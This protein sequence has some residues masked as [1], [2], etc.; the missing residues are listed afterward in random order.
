MGGMILL[1]LASAV[2]A[3]PPPK[4][5]VV[6]A[7][8][9]YRHESI[10]TAEDV[11]ASMAAT[12][13]A[14]VPQFIR[15]EKELPAA[16][17]PEAL[18]EARVVMF[19]NTTGDLKW[20]ER[21]RLLDWIAAGGSFVGVHSAS[22]TW[23][24]WPEYLEMLGGEFE[25]HPP[26]SQV[27]VHVD[28]AFHPATRHMTTP[29]TIFEEIYLFKRFSRERVHML[30]SLRASPEDGSPG[31]FPL[32]WRRH[33]GR[34]LVLYTALGHRIDVWESQWFQ[35]HLEGLIESALAHPANRR[36]AVGR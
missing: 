32:A 26:E 4:I 33:H 8:S 16:L 12:G 9:G 21:G 35:R 11:I 27:D 5:L 17:T 3:V 30:L 20:P 14:F 1:A 22:D 31:F 25:T 19:V 13:G 6:T 34:G 29:H 18:A 2:L 15:T 7:T 23:H 28:D 24:D 10:E 36:R